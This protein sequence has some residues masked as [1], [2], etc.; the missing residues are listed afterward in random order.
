MSVTLKDIAKETG[1]S[2]ATISKYIN[3]ATL[4]EQN[5]VAI[6][7]AIKKLGYTVNEYA[8]GLKSK[9]SRTVGVVIPE[10]SNLF[11][12]QI[13]TKM[14]EILRSQNYSVMI[15]DCHTDKK[16]ECDAVK[17]LLGRLTK[18]ENTFFPHW[19]RVFRFC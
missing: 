17:F 18:K 15:C 12:T 10:L 7:R 14:E 5:R 9:K 4:K 1:L 19:R 2:V 6:E 16:L 8:R 13:I 3:G 11:I